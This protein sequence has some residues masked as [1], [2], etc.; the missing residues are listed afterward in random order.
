MQE[1]FLSSQGCIVVQGGH[2]I[3][4]IYFS[5]VLRLSLEEL[6]HVIQFDLVANFEWDSRSLF[7]HYKICKDHRRT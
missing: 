3:V 4:N 1:H 2:I 6:T 7:S 5:Y